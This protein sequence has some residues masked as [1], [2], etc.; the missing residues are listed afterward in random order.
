MYELHS[1]KLNIGHFY[2]ITNTEKC[3]TLYS[4]TESEAGFQSP[5]AKSIHVLL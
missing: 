1:D 3:C 4:L 5:R 2:L